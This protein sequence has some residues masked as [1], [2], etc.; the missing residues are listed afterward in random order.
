M[1]KTLRLDGTTA[2][3]FSIG[4][5][6]NGT[7]PIALDTTAVTTAYAL[8]MPETSGLADQVLTTDGT[9][10]LSWRSVTPSPLPG[11]PNASYYIYDIDD[12]IIEITDY[13]G[14]N[15]AITTIDYD[16]DGL[17]QTVTRVYAGTTRVET[18]TYDIDG[19]VVS[20]VAAIT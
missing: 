7:Q 19:N 13:Y 6:I 2:P 15:T 3:V 12:N 8:T 17:V 18:Y 10:V 20:M 16:D 9:G 14:V 1:A 11:E 5:F 4:E